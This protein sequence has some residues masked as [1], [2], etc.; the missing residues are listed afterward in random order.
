MV[1]PDQP[2]LPIYEQGRS[3]TYAVALM[4]AA[5]GVAPAYDHEAWVWSSVP[6]S[7]P[8]LVVS[9]AAFTAC[10]TGAAAVDQRPEA[11]PDCVLGSAR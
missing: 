1:V 8:P 2:G 10:T 4:T 11:V 7:S 9:T 6:R 3:P 5:I